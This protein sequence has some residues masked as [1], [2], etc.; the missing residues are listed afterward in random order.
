[1]G[2]L[3]KVRADHPNLSDEQFDCLVLRR[4]ERPGTSGGV[5]ARDQDFTYTCPIC[6]NALFSSTAKFASGKPHSRAQTL[7]APDPHALL[8]NLPTECTHLQRDGLAII[9]RGNQR[10]SP[11]RLATDQ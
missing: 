2:G 8:D 9:L 7:P 1:M 4:T 10:S 3:S 5:F 6:G 11:N